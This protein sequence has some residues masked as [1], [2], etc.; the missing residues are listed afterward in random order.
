MT[1]AKVSELIK[2]AKGERSLSA[3]ARDTGVDKG[4][5]SRVI[6]GERIPSPDILRRIADASPCSSYEQLMLAADYISAPE[7]IPIYGAIAA[8]SPIEAEEYIEGYVKLD[9]PGRAEDY[10]ALRVSGDSMDAIGIKD[11]G[12]VIIRRESVVPDGS[13]AAVMVEGAA[14]VKQIYSDGERM[15]LLPR[16]TNSIHKPQVYS[17]D[18]DVRI[19]GRVVKGIID[20]D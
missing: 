5:L 12:I 9:M 18:R 3:F 17:Q 1:A 16:S 13:I 10:M 15:T 7:G 11:G 2:T 4:Y 14:T 8:G 6:R 20:I 19:P